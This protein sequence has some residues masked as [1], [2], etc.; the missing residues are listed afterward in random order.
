MFK[1]YLSNPDTYKN[2][3]EHIVNKFTR[4][5]NTKKIETSSFSLPFYTTKFSDGTSFM[6]AN[7][8]FSVKNMKTGDIFKAIL[9][10]EID[11][12]FI[13]TKNTEL[14]QEL[15][16]TLPLK[17]INSLDAEISKWLN[18]FKAQRH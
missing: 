13:A 18:T 7:P 12:P 14:G 5:A 15:S 4:L 3:E 1:N 10:E 11:K 17:S 16:I 6:D 2:L 8:I 9:D